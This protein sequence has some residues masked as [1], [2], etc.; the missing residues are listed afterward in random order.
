MT[1]EVLCNSRPVRSIK[2]LPGADVIYDAVGAPAVLGMH[3]DRGSLEV[4]VS[5]EKKADLLPLLTGSRE[6][7]LTGYFR[8]RSGFKNDG[9]RYFIWCLVLFSA[10][11][12]EAEIPLAA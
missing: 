1:P 11:S 8:R 3:N 4:L 10:E 9:G 5:P 2:V 6:L 7:T 12:C